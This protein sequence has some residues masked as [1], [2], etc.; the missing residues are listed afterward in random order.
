[1]VQ[2]IVRKGCEG[3]WAAVHVAIPSCVLI[4]TRSRCRSSLILF[5]SRS[6][7]RRRT[8]A[9]APMVSAFTSPETGI[10]PCLSTCS[11]RGRTWAV[12]TRRL[13]L[14]NSREVI[15]RR[16]IRTFTTLTEFVITRKFCV[17][18]PGCKVSNKPIKYI[19][20]ILLTS[21]T[22]YSQ[23]KKYS[24]IIRYVSGHI[25]R[26]LVALSAVHSRSRPQSA[27]LAIKGNFMINSDSKVAQ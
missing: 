13:N 11:G 25:A 12:E 22:T 4:R 19:V 6:A 1:M 20:Y 14:G 3:A 18:R 26:V 5:A 9:C 21:I 24:I 7:Q 23:F 27:M 16:E 17:N 2:C 15:M 10:H 8:S